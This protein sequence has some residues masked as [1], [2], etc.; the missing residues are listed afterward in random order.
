MVNRWLWLPVLMLSCVSIVGC[1]NDA[2]NTRTTTMASAPTVLVPDYR[3]LDVSYSFGAN[4]LSFARLGQPLRS[5]YANVSRWEDVAWRYFAVLRTAEADTPG[6]LIAG[7]PNEIEVL[8]GVNTQ[9]AADR[10]QAPSLGAGR[11]LICSTL[12]ETDDHRRVCGELDVP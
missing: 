8:D 1:T 7:D 6:E 3:S 11:Y 5:M 10:Y 9:R 12:A 2:T 4:E